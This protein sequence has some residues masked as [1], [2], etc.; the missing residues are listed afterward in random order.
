MDEDKFYAIVFSGEHV[1][2]YS[3]EG[4]F[5]SKNFGEIKFKKK[6]AELKERGGRHT[7]DMLFLIEMPMQLIDEA[8]ELLGTGTSIKCTKF[9]R[10]NV[11][12]IHVMKNNLI[13]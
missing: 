6:L 2:D 1:E 8:D 7:I 13:E 9:I 3:I 11:D 5:Y 4:I 10:N 12:K